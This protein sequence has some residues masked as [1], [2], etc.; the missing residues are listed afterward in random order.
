MKQN[1]TYKTRL[2]D[3]VVCGCMDPEANNYNP[4]ANV[5]VT[6][7]ENWQEL[8]TPGPIPQCSYP[9]QPKPDWYYEVIPYGDTFEEACDYID[10]YTTGDYS[11]APGFGGEYENLNCCPGQVIYGYLDEEGYC[12]GSEIVQPFTNNGQ[13]IDHCSV[14]YEGDVFYHIESVPDPEVLETCTDCSELT[15]KVCR[16]SAYM[17]LLGAESSG[18][19]NPHWY[20]GLKHAGVTGVDGAGELIYDLGL[21]VRLATKFIPAFLPYVT[22]PKTPEGAAKLVS[23]EGY[24]ILGLVGYGIYLASKK[25]LFK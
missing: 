8:C 23:L 17:Q 15:H 7:N 18:T 11:V 10:G 24:I 22:P 5:S 25:G 2:D 19:H 12:D 20:A 4:D 6:N 16:G 9:T 1:Q 3:D 21:Q 13:E 14:S